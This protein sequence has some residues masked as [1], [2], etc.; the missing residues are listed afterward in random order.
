M[1]TV[2]RIFA[3]HKISFMKQ[4][5]SIAILLSLMITVFILGS[6][7]N[8]FQVDVSDIEITNVKINRYEKALFN[9]E[10]D[11]NR[12]AE[13]QTEFPL[14]LGDFPLDSN[15][16]LQL[17]SYVSD[18]LLLDLFRKTEEVFPNFI[19]QE[20]QLTNSFKYI[21]YYYPNF[22]I[23][24]VYTYLSG[25]QD[26]AFYQDQVLMMSVDHYLGSG[27]LIYH[28]LGTPKYKQFSMKKQ[29]FVKDAL[30]SI[31]KVFINPLPGD[32]KLIEQMIYEGKLLYFIKSM[33]PEISDEILFSQTDLHLNWLLTKEAELWRY[34]IE[35]ELLYKTD[36]LA[37]NKF[38]NDAPF[39]AVLGDDSA[40]R[41]GIWIGYQIIY[42]YMINHDENLQEMLNNNRAQFILQKSKYK[43]GKN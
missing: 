37:Y 31:A 7:K 35:N 24:Q 36:Y 23:P 25:V 39:T 19:E 4:I 2:F 15:Q 42:S 12:I 9:E 41:T 6:C 13:L 11:K 38:I 20:K 29:F 8:N 26:I 22:T 33:Y 5:T 28:R 34:Y 14:F 21:K 16:I 27:Y 30:M 10:L 17:Q 1:K 40:P 32:A 18:S 3:A 43:P